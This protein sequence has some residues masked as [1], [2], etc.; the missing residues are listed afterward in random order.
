[1][2]S[3]TPVSAGTSNFTVQASSAGGTLTQ[4]KVFDLTVTYPSA[5]GAIA[6]QPGPSGS[7]CYA[8]NTVMVPSVA[9]L[10]TSTSGTPVGGVRVDLVGVTNNGSKVV[11]SQPWAITGANGLAVFDALSINKTGGYRLIASTAAPW[12]VTSVQSGRFNISPS[13]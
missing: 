7:Q 4:S 9:V 13:C 6:F 3:G 12:P 10:V 8:L 2:L 5:F 1:V 11:V